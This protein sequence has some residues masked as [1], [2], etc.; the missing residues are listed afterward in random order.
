MR[1]KIGNEMNRV[2]ESVHEEKKNNNR[3][4]EIGGDRDWQRY[5]E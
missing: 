1:N 5:R 2:G 3:R 4:I